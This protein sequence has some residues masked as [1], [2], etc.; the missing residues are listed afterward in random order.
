[1]QEFQLNVLLIAY[2]LG[3][4]D[5][6]R[7]MLSQSAKHKFSVQHVQSLADGIGLLRSRDFD[8]ILVDLALPDSQGLE[9]ALAVRN[10]ASRVPIIILTSLD[11]EDMAQKA[12]QSDIQDYLL[13]KEIT[14][15]LLQRSIRYAI[16]R[17]RDR[18]ELR[19]SKQCFESFMLNLPAAGWIKDLDGR[20]LYA[21]AEAERTFSLPLSE[22]IGKRDEEFLPPETA[23]QFVENDRR[24]LAEGGNLRTTDVLRQADGIDHLS[25]VSKFAVPA[26]DGQAAYVAGV[27]FDIT[28]QVQA[29]GALRESE[30]LCRTMFDSIDEG[31]CT[32]EVIFDDNDKPIDYRFLETNASFERQTGLVNAQGK[33][34]RELAPNHEEHWFEIYGRIA[35][36]G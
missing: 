24:V 33:R 32:I 30:A 31:F 7:E 4:A 23:R 11:D 36:T 2:D 3:E 22:F 29:E 20:Y 13:K 15:G 9:T 26:P 35:M 19:E 10:Q 17:K 27:A 8:A 21:N 18:E 14:G 6:T 16:Q 5:K 28:E 1:M 12:F 25:I 34:M